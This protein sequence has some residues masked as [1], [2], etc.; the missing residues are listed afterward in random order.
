MNQMPQLLRPSSAAAP[1][2]RSFGRAQDGANA[3]DDFADATGYAPKSAPSTLGDRLTISVGQTLPTTPQWGR[4]EPFALT[5]ANQFRPPPP[6]AP[7]TAEW[8][9]QTEV[10]I[11]ASRELTD[12]QKAA[13]EYWAP[14]GSSPPPH[15]LE[16]TRFVSNSNDL[17]LDEDVKLF[18]A[19]TNALLDAS[20]A[21]W[22]AKYVYTMCARSP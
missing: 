9:R 18:F 17:R 4:V 19:A 1:P 10:L 7:G 5:Q 13:A 20:I 15:L 11:D 14:W 16:I 21:T 8:A 3:A 2:W 6:P 12:A 22:E